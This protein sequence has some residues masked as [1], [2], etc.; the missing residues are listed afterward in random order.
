MAAVVEI[1][2]E[3][4]EVGEL[5]KW[6]D[7][8]FLTKHI[9]VNDQSQLQLCSMPGDRFMGC[10]V[11]LS[12]RDWPIATLGGQFLLT[13]ICVVADVQEMSQSTVCF[14]S[15]KKEVLSVRRN[16]TELGL[17]RII[18]KS[19]RLLLPILANDAVE[20]HTMAYS[21]CWVPINSSYMAY[22]ISDGCAHIRE[23]ISMA[24]E[25]VMVS[26]N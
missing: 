15:L 1:E 5:L 11:I 13:L 26:C 17:L 20:L 24:M 16:K 4:E 3:E 14:E 25:V 22:T 18:N 7:L 8:I 19:C 2:E 23:S 12:K 9:H 21:L 10:N 6:E